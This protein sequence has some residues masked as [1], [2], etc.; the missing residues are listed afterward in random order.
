[1][2]E[3]K[4]RARNAGVPRCYIYG[5]YVI[6]DGVSYIINNE[7]RFKVIAGTESQYI[8]QKDKNRKEIY[9]GD[10]VRVGSWWDN[11][12]FWEE[13]GTRME[14]DG[15]T[16]IIKWCGDDDYPAFDLCPHIDCDSNGLSHITATREMEIEIIGNT[17][18]NPELL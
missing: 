1:M 17:Y 13:E 14:Y 4:F 5:Y 18:E 6:E 16:H 11:S 9:E 15:T 12:D 7:G 2:R 8:G 3:I 10:I